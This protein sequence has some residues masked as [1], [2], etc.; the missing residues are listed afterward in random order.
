MD[1]DGTQTSV[2]DPVFESVVIELAA[3][4]SREAP[5]N[6]FE[7]PDFNGLR[8]HDVFLI[9]LAFRCRSGPFILH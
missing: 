4:T 5:G 7:D 3:V 9:Y 6:P 1:S 2:V 8:G